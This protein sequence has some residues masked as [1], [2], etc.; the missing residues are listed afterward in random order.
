[1]E[2]YPTPELDI[3]AE[4]ID[5]ILEEVFFVNKLIFGKFNYRKI[6]PTKK[7]LSVWKNNIE[8]YEEMV[9]KVIS[10]CEKN[11]IKYHIKF[12]TPL[13]KGLTTNIFKE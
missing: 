5:K 1:M 8:F 6:V 10:F 2:P 9:K 3:T 13:S 4:D 12:G 7:T 11:D